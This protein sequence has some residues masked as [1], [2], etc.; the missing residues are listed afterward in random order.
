MFQSVWTRLYSNYDSILDAPYLYMNTLTYLDP[1]VVIGSTMPVTVVEGGPPQMVN[2]IVKREGLRLDP[3]D[4]VRINV[5]ICSGK[6][7]CLAYKLERIVHKE[8]TD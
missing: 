1:A 7:P 2:I 8:I 3:T 6:A 4:T 5:W